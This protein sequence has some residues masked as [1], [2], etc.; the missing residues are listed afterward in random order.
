MPVAKSA[1]TVKINIYTDSPDGGSAAKSGRRRQQQQ[2]EEE[3]QPPDYADVVKG[4]PTQESMV[5]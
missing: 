2:E 4:S 3:Q 1:E 5:L